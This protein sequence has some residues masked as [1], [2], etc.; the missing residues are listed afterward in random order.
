MA[1]LHQ[2]AHRLSLEWSRLEPREG[3]FE[4]AAVARYRRMLEGLRARCI[5]PIVTLNHFTLPLWVSRAG[6]WE[7][8]RIVRWFE[9]YARR[10]AGWFADLVD[11]WVP[12][13]EPNV[14]LALGYLQGRF[15]PG[16][17]N[18]LRA[19][20]ALP[21]LLRSHAVA[22]Q[23]IH[24]V[25]RGAR[26]GT[27]HNIR[28]VDPARRDSRADRWSASLQSQFFNWLWLDVVQRGEGRSILWSGRLQEC[29]DT[30][31]FHGVNYYTRDLTRFAPWLVHRAFGRNFHTPDAEI[32]DHGYGEI[33]PEG[34]YR[35]LREVWDRYRRPLFVTENGVPDEDDDIRPRFLV[36]HLIAV[37]RAIADGIPVEGYYHWSVVDNFEWAEGWRMK[38]GLIAVD[39]LTQRRTERHSARVYAEICRG[40]VLPETIPAG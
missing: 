40:G 14:V 34:L 19:R 1:A 33:Y 17:R 27:A 35:A 23:A 29:A 21:N 37:R 5:E 15:P 20:R 10:C 39:P 32:S 36:D 4:E 31:D 6:G 25:Q 11:L 38:F 2:N 12:I 30:A 26:V 22:Y 7:N 24:D 9:R 18:P 16:A 28:L 13:N 3:V 8:P